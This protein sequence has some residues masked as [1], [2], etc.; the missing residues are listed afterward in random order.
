MWT[1]YTSILSEPRKR[2]LAF[3]SRRHRVATSSPS[4]I[5]N[6]LLK[7][8][9]SRY[10]ESIRASQIQIGVAVPVL[11]MFVTR[12]VLCFQDWHCPVPILHHY[13][14]IFEKA[15]S[16]MLWVRTVIDDEEGEGAVAYKVNARIP[17][18]MQ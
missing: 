4:E 1:A 11:P 14:S 10:T 13:S 6:T 18:T 3:S 5:A 2:R 7:R 17:N 12:D 9:A 8:A 16:W 15:Q